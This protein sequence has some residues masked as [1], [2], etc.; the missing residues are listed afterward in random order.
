MNK[1]IVFTVSDDGKTGNGYPLYQIQTDHPI[2]EGES[3]KSVHAAAVPLKMMELTEMFPD[4]DVIFKAADI[5]ISDW[6]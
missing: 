1:R 5:D 6:E 3:V 2:A 4:Y